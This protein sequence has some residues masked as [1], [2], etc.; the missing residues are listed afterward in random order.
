MVST[1]TCLV[2]DK[3]F[4]CCLCLI[5]SVLKFGSTFNKSSWFDFGNFFGGSFLNVSSLSDISET[6]QCKFIFKVLRSDFSFWWLFGLTVGVSWFKLWC[7][8]FDHFDICLLY[9]KVIKFILI[10]KR[11]RQIVDQSIYYSK[12][13]IKLNIKLKYNLQIRF[14]NFSNQSLKKYN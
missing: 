12:L 6:S 8:I 3:F 1:K 10:S 7:S 11:I 5:R 2:F 4:R 9:K 14:I 13:K